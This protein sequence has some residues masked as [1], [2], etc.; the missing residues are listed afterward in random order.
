MPRKRGRP[1]L[2]PEKASAF[3]PRKRGRPPKPTLQPIPEESI[4]EHDQPPLEDHQEHIIQDIFM[5]DD[6]DSDQASEFNPD[7]DVNAD[8]TYYQRRKLREQREKDFYA[9]HPRRSSRNKP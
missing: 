3:I 1:R 7:E 2:H 5:S 6:F 8:I 9:R 4:Q